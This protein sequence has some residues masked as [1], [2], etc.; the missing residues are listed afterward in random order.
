MVHLDLSNSQSLL[1]AWTCGCL[2]LFS[3]TTRNVYNA[4]G[5]GGLALNDV[6]GQDRRV[7]NDV[8]GQ[9]HRALNYVICQGRRALNYV[10]GQ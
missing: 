1:K 4:I 8:I 2:A 7:L 9:G 5:R 3:G 10:I 6:I